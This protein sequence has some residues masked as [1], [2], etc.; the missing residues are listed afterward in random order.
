MPQS[1]AAPGL[2]RN[3]DERQ[4]FVSAVKHSLGGASRSLDYAQCPAAVAVGQGRKITII[5]VIRK[6]KYILFNA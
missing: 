4:Q 6:S 5:L 1:P 3:G 2:Q